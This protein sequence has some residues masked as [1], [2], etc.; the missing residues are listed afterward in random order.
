MS[1][2]IEKQMKHCKKC[3]RTTEH[4][5]NNSKSSGFMI[6][7]HLILILCTAGVWLAVIVAWK[8]LN[9]KVGGWRCS[10]H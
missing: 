8:I 3:G 4:W 6:L 1:Q 2:I 9:F 5:R 10:N 7:I